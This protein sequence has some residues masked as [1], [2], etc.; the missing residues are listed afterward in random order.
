MKAFHG[1]LEEI[2]TLATVKTESA[3]FGN[4]LYLT[5][6]IDDARG[7]ASNKLYNPSDDIDWNRDLQA[8]LEFQAYM[9]T[10]ERGGET[11]SIAY[12]QLKVMNAEKKGTVFEVEYN[13]NNALILD[14]TG[15]DITT[16]RE[17]SMFKLALAEIDIV[18]DN[19]DDL[20]KS[21]NSYHRAAPRD[22][23]RDD[24][25][26]NKFQYQMDIL[27]RAKALKVLRQYASI[28]N[29]DILVIK[30]AN[31]YGLV[32]STARHESIDHIQVI[33]DE[34]IIS[35]TKIEYDRKPIHKARPVKESA[36]DVSTLNS[37]KKSTLGRS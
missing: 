2:D 17:Y 22:A 32:K 9:A 14:N 20:I 4:G 37:G 25:K 10:G 23:S 30:D 29:K 21:V 27:E 18:G 16:P 8:R 28:K 15:L 6:N 24:I 12:Q 19:A 35:S 5:S 7:Y 3:I 34:A 33:R 26:N 13:N 31:K 1:T 11:F 36:Y